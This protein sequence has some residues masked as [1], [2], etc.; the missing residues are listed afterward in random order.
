[1]QG[2]IVAVIARP[3]YPQRKPLRCKVTTFFTD[4]QQGTSIDANSFTMY[5]LRERITYEQPT[6]HNTRTADNLCCL[7]SIRSLSCNYL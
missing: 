3:N 2:I 4:T 5:D 1:M 6:M 7:L